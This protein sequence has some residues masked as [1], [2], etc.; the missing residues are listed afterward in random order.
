MRRYPRA[1]NT[2]LLSSGCYRWGD[3][4]LTPSLLLID[5]R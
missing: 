1:I 5:P 2:A 3:F 4:H